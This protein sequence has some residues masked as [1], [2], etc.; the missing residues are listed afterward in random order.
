MFNL[1]VQDLETCVTLSLRR[2]IVRK[3]ECVLRGS[4]YWYILCY[5]NHVYDKNYMYI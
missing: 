5:S 2:G 3:Y 1:Y 4:D